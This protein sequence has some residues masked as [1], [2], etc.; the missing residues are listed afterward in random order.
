MK[1]TRQKKR[2]GGWGGGRETEKKNE[3]KDHGT[4]G[5]NDEE[6]KGATD[7]EQEQKRIMTA[8]MEIRERA[9]REDKHGVMS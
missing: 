3:E 5:R 2:G 4:W 6:G 7:S 1:A 9:Q 8:L